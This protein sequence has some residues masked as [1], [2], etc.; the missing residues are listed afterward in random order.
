MKKNRIKDERVQQMRNKVF[1]EAYFVMLLLLAL[2]IFIKTYIIKMDVTNYMVE[3]IV[4]IVSLIYI[5][6]R[7]MF[8][9]S[10]ILEIS[11]RKIRIHILGIILLSLLIAAVGG[12]K[13][14]SLYKNLYTGIMDKHFI[15]LLCTY[16]ISSVILT[17][18][19][20]AFL[21]WLH[22]KEQDRIKKKIGEDDE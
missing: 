17:S 10:E 7:G 15:A 22:K 12:V 16:F 9:G 6:V 19:C 2:S 4:V 8:L 20:F 5:G 18:V 3:L 14:Y 13:N 11:K 21:Y 1:G